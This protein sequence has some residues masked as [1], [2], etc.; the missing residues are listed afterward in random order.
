MAKVD[1]HVH[2]KYSDHPS[3]WA[4]KAYNSPES[5]TEIETVYQQAKSRGMDFV[6]LTDHDDIRGSLELVKNH[7]F[8]CFVSCE[9]TTHFP[10][11]H[12][13]AHI[14]VFGINTEQYDRML[15]IA[16]NIYDLR[17]YIASQNI[18]YS[19]AHAAYD[20]D[21]KLSFEHIEKLVL[22][23]DVFETINGGSDTQTNLLVNR[24]LQNLDETQLQ[25][26]QAKHKLKPISADPWV[27]GFTGGSDD[28][29]GILIGSAYT[30]SSSDSI[31]EFLDSIRN[32][33]S[34]A[35][36]R[37]G[38]FE[39]YATG[40][41]KHIHDYRLNRDLAY[42]S[43]KMND[44]LE[45]FFDGREGNL[46]KRFKKSQ[47]LR[48][49]KKK[50][51]KTHKALHDLLA[52]IASDVN[53]EISVKIPNAYLQVTELHDEMF[54]SVLTAF[55]KHLPNGDIFKAVNRLATL[56]PM[57]LLAA[58][59][60]GSLRHQVVKSEIKKKLLEG[61]HQHY[62]EKALWFTDT[63]D[64]LNGVSVTLH[65]IAKHGIQH[66]YQLKLV[67][68]VDEGLIRTPLPQNTLNFHPVKQITIPGY[69]TQ[70]LGFPSLLTML[71]KLAHEQPDQ[72]IISTPGPLGITAMVCAKLMDLPVK[73]IY[74]TDFAEQLLRMTNEPGLAN[75]VDLAVNSF[76]KK[77]DYVFVPSNFY[78]DKLTQRG[79]D[80]KRLGIF[81]RGLDLELYRPT[82]SPA[83]L[84]RRHQLHGKFTLLF[85][86]RISEDKNL[87]LLTQ[88]FKQLNHDT[89]GLYNLVV[90]GDGPGLT[91]LKNTLCNERNLL[92]TGRL[93]PKELVQW[94]QSADLMVFPSH[95]DTFGMVVLE[96]QA[97][98]LPCLVT[99]T[100]G[101][102]EIIDANVTGQIINTD[103]VE[104]W[105]AAINQYYKHK[106]T[107]PAAWSALSASCALHV[108][109]QNNWQPV[110]DAVL[111]NECRLPHP[112][113]ESGLCSSLEPSNSLERTDSLEPRRPDQPLKNKAK[114]A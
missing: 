90:A 36:G 95:T 47:S 55:V 69:E 43:S 103:N 92:L 24:Y 32:K 44:F 79:L 27:K 108:H 58:P 39:S 46:L 63:I 64:D 66:G 22:L 42:K 102:K 45:L 5:F 77:S 23:F 2:S 11:D 113:K 61:T 74:H 78:I 54:R 18:A 60:I 56:F 81:P 107:R 99:A 68:C 10:E 96:A 91:F 59:F 94:Y 26:L 38:S 83:D 106:T 84:A 73:T 34:C 80:P 3:T 31:E 15:A 93:D 76:Y 28:H 101:P 41:I 57:T 109:Q 110:F 65:Q 86:G 1:L 112:T 13:Q 67:T 62:T 51:T 33:N 50:N 20:Q 4:L 37:H 30:Q 29:C 35:N 6:T 89:P 16:S 14:L 52:Q 25:Q 75:L 85:A 82:K 72:I 71:R 7:P 111:G 70:S 104:D 97:C 49:L 17:D 48:Y 88:I 19:V 87:S 21:G 100:G 98:G 9:I 40:V 53:H 12:C 8:D 105:I 114:A